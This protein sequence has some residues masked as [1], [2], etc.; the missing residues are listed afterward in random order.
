MRCVDERM[1]QVRPADGSPA[2]GQTVVCGKCY[3]CRHNKTQTWIDRIEM[4][5]KGSVHRPLFITMTYDDTH[6]PR[7]RNGDGCLC[8]KHVQDFF[9]RLR[10]DISPAK[11]RYIYLGEYGGR[12]V[13]PH[14]HIILFGCPGSLNFCQT[15]IQKHWPYGHTRTT[16]VTARRVAYIASYH[17]NSAESPDGRPRPFVQYSRNPGIGYCYVEEWS[18]VRFHVQ[19][20][21]NLDYVRLSGQKRPLP[22][23]IRQRLFPDGYPVEIE[24]QPLR[25]YLAERYPD[26]SFSEAIA[27]V[28]QIYKRRLIKQLQKHGKY[29]QPVTD[30]SY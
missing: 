10:K 27:Y 26:M 30:A 5:A 28:Q 16:P 6:L 18:N 19:E 20:R 3:A 17:I 13:R 29:I 21:P 8:L 22:R 7:N 23:Y 2:Y 4:E 15:L 14:Y 12:T 9:K 24:I 25:L 11:V 1:I